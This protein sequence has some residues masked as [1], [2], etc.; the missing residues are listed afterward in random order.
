MGIKL[1]HAP[2]AHVVAF[3]TTENK[4]HDALDLGAD[5]VVVSRNIEEMAAHAG[6]LDL[7]INSVA[8]KH[9]LNRFLNLLQLDGTMALV[10]IP[11]ESHP[12]P[13]MKA[14]RL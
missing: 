12:S 5:E 4:R 14:R 7:I 9:D 13:F 2:G 11:A 1:A 6:T 8:V 10:G 3:T